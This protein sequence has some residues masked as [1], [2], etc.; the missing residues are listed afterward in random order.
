M[1]QE[2]LFAEVE[3]ILEGKSPYGFYELGEVEP[4]MVSPGVFFYGSPGHSDSIGRWIRATRKLFF[5]VGFRNLTSYFANERL[6][7]T[8]RRWYFQIEIGDELHVV[9][10]CTDFS[11]EGSKARAIALTYLGWYSNMPIEERP[12]S[13]LID[14]LV[15]G[16]YPWIKAHPS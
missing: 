11:G 4:K 8:H 5:D 15:D 13:L 16:W 12:V 2:A 10:G 3:A 1:N 6:E 7:G 9:G 14:F